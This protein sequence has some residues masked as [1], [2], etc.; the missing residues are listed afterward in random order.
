MGKEMKDWNT[1]IVGPTRSGRP[2]TSSTDRK[3]IGKSMSSLE[4]IDSWQ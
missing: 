1:D 2:Q 3:K 4:R